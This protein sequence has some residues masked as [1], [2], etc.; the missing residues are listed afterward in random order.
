MFVIDTSVLIDYL[1]GRP[2]TAE[3]LSENADRPFFA[4]TISM[5]EVYVGELAASSSAR[6]V[7][8]CN[9]RLD[10]LEFLPFEGADASEAAQIYDELRANGDLINAHDILIGGTARRRGATVVTADE[11]YRNIA[12]L[13]V[14]LLRRDDR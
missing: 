3:F 7:S 14:S 9:T 6:N 11:D 4:T 13:D 1:D 10:W 12:D 8:N 2:Y 5:Y